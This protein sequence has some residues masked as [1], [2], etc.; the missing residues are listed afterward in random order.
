MY[1][2]GTMA[3]INELIKISNEFKNVTYRWKTVSTMLQQAAFS[4][5]QQTIIKSIDK[6]LMEITDI[7]EGIADEIIKISKNYATIE[8]PKTMRFYKGFDRKY[9]LINDYANSLKHLNL[10]SN[11][12]LLAIDIASYMNNKAFGDS[13]SYNCAADINGRGHYL[14]KDSKIDSGIIKVWN[15]EFNIHNISNEKNDNISCMGQTIS[16]PKGFYKD[17][18]FIGFSVYGD[19]MHKI[20]LNKNTDKCNEIM[21]GFTNWHKEPE[22][23]EHI[24]WTGKIVVKLGDSAKIHQYNTGN[25]F[26]RGVALPQDME[27]NSIT[28]PYCPTMHIFCM[29]L[30][31]T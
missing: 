17:I 12:D 24:A 25:I 21:L 16:I 20:I 10:E 11:I 1:Y 29:S 7:E 28:L 2:I 15:N 26:I 6:D 30:S 22:F 27:I 9:T 23:N 5:H 8:V 18:V 19:S 14:L 31:K 3:K 4:E 13:I